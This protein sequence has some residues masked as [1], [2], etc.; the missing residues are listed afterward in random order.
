MA[1]SFVL[2]VANKPIMLNVVMLIVVAPVLPRSQGELPPAR[3]NATIYSRN[4]TGTS[5]LPYFLTVGS[6]ERK[7]FITLPLDTNTSNYCVPLYPL[8]SLCVSGGGI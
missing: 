8:F 4:K 5:V 7:M 3:A 1:V 6:Y 2:S